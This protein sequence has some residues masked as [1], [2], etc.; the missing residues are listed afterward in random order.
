MD[1][2]FRKA[3]AM[4]GL[5]G[6][7]VSGRE[8]GVPGCFRAGEYTLPLFRKTYVMGILNITPDSFSDGGR[9]PSV[10]EAVRRAEQMVSEG[11]DIIDVGG[12]STRP[13]HVPVDAAEEMSR[14]LPVI[15]ALNKELKVPISVDTWKAVVAKA[16]VTDGASII[17]D[18]WGLKR[19][20][21]IAKIAAE[22]G[23]GLIM[24]F[25]AF[26]PDLFARTGDIAADA[27]K[28]L[29]GSIRIAREAGAGDDQIMIDPGI[30][31]GVDTEESLTLIRSLPAFCGLGFPVLIGP[32][33]KRFIGAVLDKPVDGR[34]IGTVSVCLTGVEL[35]ASAVRV[36]DV[37][38]V[39]E[40]LRMRSAVLGERH[41]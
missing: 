30:G 38:E 13:G 20:P 35:G 3:S 31:F 15:R 41:P 24:M 16:A 37:Y 8:T 18:I 39:S 9:Y 40:A 7:S 10:E 12:E 33:R 23:A 19:E 28:Y 32:S 2:I 36:H 4:T 34:L 11:A 25:N 5:V 29:E 22:T 21:E 27:L 26:D 6:S 17:N 14:I 1:D